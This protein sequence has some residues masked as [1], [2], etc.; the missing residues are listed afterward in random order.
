[1]QWK[2]VRCWPWKG[3]V[4]AVGI[5]PTSEKRVTKATTCVAVFRNF[6]VGRGEDGT[7][8]TS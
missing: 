5:E 8:D 6:A 2:K 4:E 1:M 3:M 7:P